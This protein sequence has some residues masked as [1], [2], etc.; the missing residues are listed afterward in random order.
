MNVNMGLEDLPGQKVKCVLRQV[1]QQARRSLDHLMNTTLVLSLLLSLGM[2]D[3]L[4][5]VRI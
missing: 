5:I 4:I 2:T 1:E 3:C